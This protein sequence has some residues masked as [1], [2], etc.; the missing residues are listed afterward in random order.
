M[1][2]LLA[3]AWFV[4]A[5]TTWVSAADEKA[6]PEKQEETE[7]PKPRDLGPPL[8]DNVEAL[9]R[10][11][12]SQP[13]WVDMKRKE[14]IFQG[15]TCKAS[16]PL[17][18]LVT[19][20]GREYE[21]VIVARVRPSVVHTGLLAVGAQPGTPVRFQPKFQPPSGSEVEILV[22]WKDKDGKV[23]EARAQEWIRAIKTKKS[24]TEN[25]IFGGSGFSVDDGKRYYQAESGDFISVA[26]VPIATLDLPIE[27]AS[28]LDNRMFEGFVE[29]MPPA[30]TPVTVVLRPKLP[31]PKQ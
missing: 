8:V 5:W 13:V 18:F 28:D 11:S 17:E 12:P 15:E 1:L 21:S 27:S 6:P 10:L 3:C 2:R 31:Q 19:L 25:W 9:K 22:R 16:Y 24:P 30:E 4:L 20:P 7:Q 14:V 26:N 29:R 23:R